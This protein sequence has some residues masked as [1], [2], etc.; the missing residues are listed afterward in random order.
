M[1]IHNDNGVL[2]LVDHQVCSI[3]EEQKYFIIKS[4]YSINK[5]LVKELV[6]VGRV[7]TTG[8]GYRGG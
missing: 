1:F 5:E 4:M 7:K 6:M 3:N 8:G 2:S